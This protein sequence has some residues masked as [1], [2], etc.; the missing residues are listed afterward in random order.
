MTASPC[1]K[2]REVS[3]RCMRRVTASPDDVGRPRARCP[4]RLGPLPPRVGRSVAGARNR[5]AD[6]YDAADLDI[7]WTTARERI[8]ELL[9]LI[10]PL[11]PPESGE[12]SE[13][14]LRRGRITDPGDATGGGML[15]A[16]FRV[17]PIL[18]LRQADIDPRRCRVRC[19]VRISSGPTS[20][21][22]AGSGA[23]C[24]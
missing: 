4:F 20:S 15:S 6:G 14:E 12:S 11:I 23:P 3:T 17:F 22:A 9:A 7:V 19:A 18:R 16:A 1:A 13:D 21:E 5:F 10:E 8:P 2:L 24:G